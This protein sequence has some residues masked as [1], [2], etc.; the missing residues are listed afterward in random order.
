MC[1][2]TERVKF[3]HE[4]TTTDAWICG[5]KSTGRG[6]DL[7]PPHRRVAAWASRSRTYLTPLKLRPCDAVEIWL[8]YFFLFPFLKITNLNKVTLGYVYPN[9]LPCLSIPKSG[10]PIYQWYGV[11]PSVLGQDRSDTRKIGPGLGHCGL[12]IAGLVLC[13]E[14]WSCYARR[15]NDLEGHSGFSNTIYSLFCAW[16]ITTVEIDSGVHLFKS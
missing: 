2:T 16:N 4:N 13:C 10:V 8:V 9:Q 12:G 11:R 5:I 6:F 15:H 1:D 7:R 3:K 14:R